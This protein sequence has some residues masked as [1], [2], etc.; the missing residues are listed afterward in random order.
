MKTLLYFTAIWCRP[1]E[2]MKPLITKIYEDNKDFKLEII[3]VD[4]AHDLR[5]EYFIS[6]VPTF[7]LIDNNAE[8]KRISGAK[9]ED[10][11]KEF[12]YG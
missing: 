2:K 6:S 1:C 4:S 9:T 12:I 3:D 11:M 8:L 5:E 10:F 7:I